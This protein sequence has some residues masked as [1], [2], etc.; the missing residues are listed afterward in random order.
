[1]EMKTLAVEE[2]REAIGLLIVAG[3]MVVLAIAYAWRPR[4]PWP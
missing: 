2:A 3:W 4:K 1:M